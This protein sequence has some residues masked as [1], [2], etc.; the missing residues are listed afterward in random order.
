MRV[1]EHLVAVAVLARVFNLGVDVGAQELDGGEFMLADAPVDDLVHARVGIEAPAPLLLDERNREGPRLET[2][3]EYREIVGVL[4]DR[5][6]LLRGPVELK[7]VLA[8]L[9]RVRAAA[10]FVV[11][12]RVEERLEGGLVLGLA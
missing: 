4:A 3:D 7:P 1:L 10:E 5:E 9:D 6:L 8:P 2:E 12:R 11:A